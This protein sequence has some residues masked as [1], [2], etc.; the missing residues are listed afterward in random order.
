MR[1]LVI[2]VKRKDTWIKTVGIRTNARDVLIVE[3]LSIKRM[4]VQ[5]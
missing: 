5:S 4:N 1:I 3:I 2:L